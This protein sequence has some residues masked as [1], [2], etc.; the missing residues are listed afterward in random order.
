MTSH[1]LLTAVIDEPQYLEPVLVL[2]IDLWEMGW[3]RKRTVI[4][5]MLS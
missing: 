4:T 5:P 1:A 2:P 3:L